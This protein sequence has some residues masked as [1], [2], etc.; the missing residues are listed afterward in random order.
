MS[1]TKTTLSKTAKSGSICTKRRQTHY[2]K[3]LAVS[4]IY[5]DREQP[6]CPKCTWTLLTKSWSPPNLPM[7]SVTDPDGQ[8]RYPYDHTYYID[9]SE[10]SSDYD[11][12]S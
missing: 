1:D 7:I 8:V 3:F 12:D 10:E 4:D 6:T 5:N 11:T 2:D 9:E